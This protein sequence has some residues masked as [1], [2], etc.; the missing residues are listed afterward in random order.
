MTSGISHPHAGV[1]I[2]NETVIV[3]AL[4][5]CLRST[6]APLW[7]NTCRTVESAQA[8]W[9]TKRVMEICGNDLI[10]EVISQVAADDI[11]SG[12]HKSQPG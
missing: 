3:E 10:L 6:S 12:L 9:N 5:W 8:T 2:S 1:Q 11:E 4:G 7:V